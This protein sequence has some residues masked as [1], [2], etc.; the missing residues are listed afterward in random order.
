M[1]WTIDH[2]KQAGGR[3]ARTL[4]APAG[5][6]AGAAGGGPP[7]WRV[8]IVHGRSSSN[9]S[10]S[11]TPPETIYHDPSAAWPS[12]SAV[13]G[14]AIPAD[15]AAMAQMVLGSLDSKMGKALLEKLIGPGA[16]NL[17]GL[18]HMAQPAGRDRSF[19]MFANVSDVPDNILDALENQYQEW[20]TQ[21]PA[22]KDLLI[23][24]AGP[25]GVYVR[26]RSAI[27]DA[28]QLEE[29]ISR[30]GEVTALLNGPV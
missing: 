11:R 8:T 22:E 9:N 26:T 25:D 13:F 28:G 27:R 20:A 2:G 14:P 4:V 17:S 10:G 15:M 30:A 29:F 23:V 24:I 3:A 5:P 12:G 19:S 16:A 18:K 1:G 6:A 7:S 21:Y